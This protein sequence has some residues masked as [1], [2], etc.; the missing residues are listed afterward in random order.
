MKI[1]V[2]SRGSPDYLIDIVTDGLVR[3]AGRSSL[4][5]DY[6]VRF[7]AGGNGAYQHLCQGIQGPEPFDIHEAEVLV[8][9]SR[10][11]ENARRWKSKTGRSKV[12]IIDGEDLGT[13]HA[14]AISTAKVYFKREYFHFTP[15]PGNVKPLPF[16]AIPEEI[17]QG[18]TRRS[19]VFYSGHA[20][21]PFRNEI[22]AALVSLGFPPA[23]NRDKRI[24]NLSLT[25]ALVGVAVRGMGWDTYR[26]WEV[27]YFGAA[28]L[29]QRPQQVIPGNF[30]DGEEAVFYDGVADFRAKLNGLTAKADETAVLAKAGHQAVLSR[31]LSTN[32]A[33]TVLEA[34]L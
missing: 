10:S 4:S 1:G 23:P 31:H 17:P 8:A 6:N 28:L 24:Y 29:A 18:A 32:R 30:V 21:H 7:E 9:S 14:G 12:A 3:V 27:P 20:N 19:G 34:L 2:I 15:Y 33:R 16:A 5:I 11:A 22:A 25:S 13:L 26:Y